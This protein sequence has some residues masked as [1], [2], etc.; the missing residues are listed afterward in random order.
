M[1]IF[2]SSGCHLPGTDA[3]SLIISSR[4][5]ICMYFRGMPLISCHRRATS[6]NLS[7]KRTVRGRVHIR[8]PLCHHVRLTQAARRHFECWHSPLR[9]SHLKFHKRSHLR[10]TSNS[11]AVAPTSSF[12]NSPIRKSVT[13]FLSLSNSRLRRYASNSTLDRQLSICPSTGSRPPP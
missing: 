3:K 6:E 10:S 12:D 11:E 13:S 9:C 2:A 4:Y 5:C 1:I 8:V 7:G